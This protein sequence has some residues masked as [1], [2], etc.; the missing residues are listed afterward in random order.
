MSTIPGRKPYTRFFYLAV[1]RLFF[2]LYPLD[3]RRGTAYPLIC[4]ETSRYRSTSYFSSSCAKHVVMSLKL[5]AIY[6]QK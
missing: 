1:Y 4:S 3:P 5:N 6:R 2:C